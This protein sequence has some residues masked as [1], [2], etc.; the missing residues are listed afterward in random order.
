MK[1]KKVL[2]AN[3][4]EIAVRVIRACREQGSPPS[5]CSRR[6]TAR[7]ST[8]SWPT[9]RIRSG[10]RRPRES[11]LAIDKLVRGRAAPPAP[12]PCIPATASSPRTP[13]FAE[14][15]GAA[16]LDLRGPAA[17]GH[18]RAWATRRRRGGIARELGVPMVPGHARAGGRTTRRAR[19][20]AR[21]R[22]SGDAQGRAGRRR[23]GH[24]PRPRAR[25]SWPTRCAAARARGGRG[26]RRRRRLP[27][28]LP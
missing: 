12:T 28:A 20:R 2:V 22:L 16:G 15:C 13:R 14:A 24:A 19:R 11:Y 10:R 9:R 7:R 25:R 5:P 21:D 27:R 1:I 18:P 17:G 26:L 23:Q 4:G 3:R 6:P 8:C